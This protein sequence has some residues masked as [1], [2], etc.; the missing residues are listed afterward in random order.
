MC[1]IQITE[2][3]HI[4]KQKLLAEMVHY[5]QLI[6]QKFRIRISLILKAF[7]VFITAK[8]LTSEVHLNLMCI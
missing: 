7:S 4:L 6:Y 3:S 5:I 8:L 1:T 2:S